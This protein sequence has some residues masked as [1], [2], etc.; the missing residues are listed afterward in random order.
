MNEYDT[1]TLESTRERIYFWKNNP[2][3]NEKLI[4]RELRVGP[5]EENLSERNLLG[6]QSSDGWIVTHNIGT[7][8]HIKPLHY[9]EYAQQDVFM[10]E[11]S[12]RKLLERAMLASVGYFSLSTELRFIE[13]DKAKRE[14]RNSALVDKYALN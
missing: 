8:M 7:I 13:L 11:M 3:N 14:N 1:E 4:R 5:C 6:L 2:E 12:K 10:F 9:E